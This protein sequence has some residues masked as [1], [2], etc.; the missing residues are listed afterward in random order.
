VSVLAVPLDP[1]APILAGLALTLAGTVLMWLPVS[2]RY[3]LLVR[4]GAQA[5]ALNQQA[6]Q[7]PT[8]GA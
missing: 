8:V 1:S 6:E 3:F 2:S 4:N 7:C 5:E